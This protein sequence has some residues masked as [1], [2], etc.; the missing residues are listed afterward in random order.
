MRERNYHGWQ[1]YIDSAWHNSGSRI[2]SGGLKTRC[3][4]ACATCNACSVSHAC[5]HAWS[6]PYMI[7]TITLIT[8]TI[9]TIKITMMIMIIIIIVRQAIGPGVG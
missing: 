4:T 6:G 9:T 1:Y 8:I 2:K 3:E 7:T 5:V